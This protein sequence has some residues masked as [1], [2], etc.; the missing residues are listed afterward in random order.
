[1][2]LPGWLDRLLA[3]SVPRASL[4]GDSLTYTA[5]EVIWRS[6]VGVA[7]ASAGVSGLLLLG[8]ETRSAVAGALVA[9]GVSVVV[10]VFRSFRTSQAEIRRSLWRSAELDLLHARINLISERLGID[11]INLNE[12]FDQIVHARME[13]LAHFGGLDELRLFDDAWSPGVVG[14]EFWSESAQ[15]LR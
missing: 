4:T 12:D 14:C 15:G 13:R 11:T 9:W 6:V 10:W 8:S 5:T 2:R 3:R 1:M 7:A